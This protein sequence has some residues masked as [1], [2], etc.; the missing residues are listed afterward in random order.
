MKPCDF[1]D[2]IFRD[3]YNL[4]RHMQ[5]KHPEEMD[6][7]SEEEMDYESGQEDLVRDK[8]GRNDVVIY[9]MMMMIPITVNQ[10]TVNQRTV[11]RRKMK[12]KNR[13]S[14]KLIP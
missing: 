10:I 4:D 2:K 11:I 14:L 12:V 6:D 7:E 8:N 13:R 9:L 3:Q 5:M 1:C